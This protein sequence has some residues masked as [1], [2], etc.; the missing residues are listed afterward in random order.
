MPS[1]ACLRESP[2]TLE[3]HVALPRHSRKPRHRCRSAT[4]APCPSLENRKVASCEGKNQDERSDDSLDAR[5]GGGPALCARAPCPWEDLPFPRQI[6][7][8]PDDQRGYATLNF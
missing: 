4:E 5:E 7:R 8:S 3:S 6:W 1:A 2:T